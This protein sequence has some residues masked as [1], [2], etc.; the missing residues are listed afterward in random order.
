ML[1]SFAAIYIKALVAA[2]ASL[3][4][5]ARVVR[6]DGRL[7]TF[8]ISYLGFTAY[9][10]AGGA[11]RDEARPTLRQPPRRNAPHIRAATRRTGARRHSDR[12]AVA[13]ALRRV[14]ARHARP[15]ALTDARLVA[16]YNLRRNV[17]AGL[18]AL[19]GVHARARF[20]EWPA[21]ARVFV[22]P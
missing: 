8:G 10:C 17:R 3:R 5:R 2:T 20:L 7:A 6:Y 12:V 21:W 1:A 22:L 11:A 16:T 19:G 13:R 9:A 4:R 18:C 14:R 15:F